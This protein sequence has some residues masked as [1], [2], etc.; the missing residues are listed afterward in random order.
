MFTVKRRHFLR[1]A[2]ANGN[3]PRQIRSAA[4]LPSIAEDSFF[5]LLGLDSGT[6]HRSLSGH[7]AYVSRRQRS[8]RSAE[9]SDRRADRGKNVDC[10]Q[11]VASKTFES[12]RAG[13]DAEARLDERVLNQNAFDL[14][15]VLEVFAVNLLALTL[16]SRRDDQRVIPRY[17]MFL[18]DP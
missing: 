8:Q 14:S 10:L 12:S 7:H 13:K 6:L 16:Q 5:H 1:H 15:T 18:D 4:S 3:L 2:A 11:R 17:P 9:L